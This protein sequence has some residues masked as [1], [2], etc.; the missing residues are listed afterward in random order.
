MG[1][2]LRFPALYTQTSKI[3]QILSGMIKYINERRNP[4]AWILPFGF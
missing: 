3:P 2:F 1:D 4:S